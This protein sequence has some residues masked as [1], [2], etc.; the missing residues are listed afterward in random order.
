[1]NHGFLFKTPVLKSGW[2]PNVT[3]RFEESSTPEHNTDN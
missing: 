3:D 1:M 2:W